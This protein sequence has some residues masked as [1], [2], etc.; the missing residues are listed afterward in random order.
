MDYF[1]SI[2]RTNGPSETADVITAV[3]PVVSMSMNEALTMEFRAKEVAK[4]L[5]QMHPKKS[6]GPNGMPPLFYQHYWSLVGNYVTKSVLDFL[7]QGIS[8]PSFDDTHIIL[9]PKVKNPTKI[10]H[11][12]PISLS[13][14]VSR[15]ASKVLTNRLKVLFPHIISE[16]QSAFMSNHLI[17][18]NVLV[19]FETMHHISQKKG[20]KV[21]EMALKFD[22][23][24]A[25]DRV[26]WGGRLMIE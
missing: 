4:V 1:H 14:V 20:G 7:N 5:K 16:N 23:S 8:P 11:Y 22:I 6:P 21:G 13:N 24:K 18:D 25:Y 12:H 9:I 19:T 26:E 2:F 17:T 15:L 10:T 3:Q